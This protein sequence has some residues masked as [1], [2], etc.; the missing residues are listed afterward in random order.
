MERFLISGDF[1]QLI[2]TVRGRRVML[3]ADLARIYGVTPKRLNQQVHRNIER[4]P[5][6]FMFQLT[7]EEQAVLRLQ[8]ATLK[9]GSG[10]YRKYLPY[11]FTE[12]GAVMLSAV[13]RTPVAIQASIQ[14]V[15]A[16][17]RLR[18]LS[19]AHRDLAAALGELERRVAAHDDRLH[20]LFAAIRELVDPPEPPRKKIGF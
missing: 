3:D 5:N 11:A 7:S 13:L 9:P 10:H 12:H 15:R 2:H 1:D 18:Q 20:A 4:F 8:N 17:N 19:A 14:V 16:F 6:D